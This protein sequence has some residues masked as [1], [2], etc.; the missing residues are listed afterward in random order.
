M[1]RL[2]LGANGY[3]AVEAIRGDMG[4]S[5]FE[6]RINKGILVYKKR[7]EMMDRGRWARIMYEFC[8][9][10]GY[11]RKCANIGRCLGFQKAW[12]L[13]LQGDAYHWKIEIGL[14][15]AA[16]LSFE[17]WKKII[18]GSIA[19]L[20]LEKWKRGM[21]GK[22]TLHWY[23]RKEKP[24]MERCYDGSPNSTLL[25]KA[26]TQSLE[27]NARTYRWSET[28]SKMCGVCGDGDE[29]VEHVMVECG[30]YDEM[31]EEFKMRSIG[32]LGRGY[33]SG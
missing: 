21:V 27:V 28:G 3:V 7:L 8:Q 30:G 25:F 4:W 23:A 10:G 6:E 12:Q 22:S 29:T 2:G 5:S 16:N 1:G 19:D 17:K 26:R 32:N 14:E 11:I 24:E 15:G 18:N 33:K 13:N 31:R 9:D 20:G